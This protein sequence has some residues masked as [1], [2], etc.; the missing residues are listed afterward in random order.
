MREEAR[1]FIL[2]LVLPSSRYLLPGAFV[3]L[4][5]G[6]GAASPSAEREAS[7]SRRPRVAEPPSGSAPIL[8]VC[9]PGQLSDDGICVHLPSRE[10]DGE[11]DP[12]VAANGHR[13]RSGRW[14]AYEDIPRRPERPADYD[15]Y[16]YP[17]PPGLPGGHSVVSGFDLDKPDEKQRRGRTLH[18]VG[19]GGVDLPDP[20][21]TPITMV[22]LDHQVG[23]AEVLFV[24]A[25]FGTTVI[26]RQTVKEGGRP[27]D[28]LVLFGHMDAVGPEVHVGKQLKDGDLVGLVGD[29][30]SPEL[31]HL[32][33]EARRMRDGVDVAAK[34]KLGPGAL[35]A[36]DASVVCDPRNVLPLR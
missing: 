17:V 19:H 14:A 35:F 3:L 11:D 16:R 30:G 4:A 5:G 29:T 34:A 31:V 2:V 13:T 32:H 28:Y 9:P 23:D 27:R 22:A 18:A 33:Y 12:L 36:D 20:R 25:Y 8:S 6:I 26:A 21:G 7:P 15:A 24:G 1:R 10:D